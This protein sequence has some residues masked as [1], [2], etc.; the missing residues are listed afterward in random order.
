MNGLDKLSQVPPAERV[1]LLS[2]CLRPAQSCPGKFSREGLICPETCPEA[3]CLKDFR[4]TAL[5]LGYRGVCIAA[6]GAMA[7]NFV[8]KYKPK[9]IVAV[10]CS[11]ELEEGV[12]RV[13]HS[14]LPET[15]VIVVIPLLRDGCVD[16]EV[17]SAKV[18]EAITS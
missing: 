17:D 4:E 10:A 8:R 2:H 16:T 1:L 3:C 7:V 14:D 9:G 5:R 12:E 15:P 18:I 11:R 6:G 13:M